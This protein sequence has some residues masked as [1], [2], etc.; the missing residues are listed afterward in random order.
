[1]TEPQPAP[2]S[3]GYIG[4]YCIVGILARGGMGEV[5][6]A[7]DDRLNRSVAIKRIRQDLDNPTLRQR[8]LQEA[9][10]VGGLHHPAIVLVYDLLEHEGD[11]CIVMEHVEGPTVAEA[12]KTG[13]LEPGPAVRLAETVASGLAAAHEAGFIHRDLKAENVKVTPSGD[14]KILDFGL[15]KPLGTAPDDPSLTAAGH[16]V[17]TC[18]SMSPEQASG[19]EVDERSDLF[20]LGVL[21]YEMLAGISPFQSSSA[22][23][24]LHKVIYERP[25]CLDTLR[26]GLPPRLVALLYRLLAKEPADRPQ[27][28]VEVV[29]E[30]QEIAASLSLSGDLDPEQTVSALPTDTIRRWGGDPTPPRPTLQAVPAPP[31]ERPPRRGRRRRLE[32]AILLSLPLLLGVAIL[33]HWLIRPRPL[34]IVVPSPEISGDPQLQL[35]ASSVQNACEDHLF[36]LGIPVIDHR[37]LN[38]LPDSS[39]I[40]QVALEAAADEVLVIDARRSDNSS[41]RVELRCIRGKDGQVLWLEDLQAP[42]ERQDFLSLK[43]DALLRKHLSGRPPGPRVPAHVEAG[44]LAAFYLI[45]RQ[46]EQG[47]ISPESALPQLQA[48]IA[49]SR[50][51]LDAQLLAADLATD[52]F[53]SR[54]EKTDYDRALN[55]IEQAEKLA[56]E[57]PRPLES[58]FRLQ[59]ANVRFDEA[60]KTLSNLEDLRPGDP[61]N[62]TLRADLE[63]AQGQYGK[64]LA[65]QQGAVEALPSWQNILKLAQLEGQN[66][67]IAEARSHLNNILED[68]P[69]NLWAQQR[70]GELEIEFGDP[71]RAEAI[72]Q[73]LISRSSDPASTF[74]YLANLG[75]ARVLLSRYSD[76][77]AALNEAL[78]IDPDNVSATLN[79]ADAK[80]GLGQTNDAQ[81][82]YSKI[83]QQLERNAPSGHTAYEHIEAQCLAHLGKTH[84]AREI[85]QRA[86]G[87]NADN[88]DILQ[89]A[90]LVYA[91][92]G[93][94]DAALETIQIALGKQLASR[95]FKTP[96]YSPLFGDPKFQQLVD[97]GKKQDR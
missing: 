16:V 60:A 28:A 68:S 51:F 55:L 19:A 74:S 25:P 82:L 46:F 95:W 44:D 66:G 8:L 42:L 75:V 92:A 2:G 24:T 65:D 48:I 59:M 81:A 27:S 33:L 97:P 38:G 50:H 30:L 14:A 21:L 91:L 62:L 63:K 83:L 18:R 45:Q 80:L 11:D 22:P 32:I 71:E 78:K 6:L 12:L 23:A 69:G 9:R 85:I 64:A 15:A 29:R 20:S 41:A 10:A 5:Y 67:R 73:K 40:S 76:A 58:L 34:R 86:L 93:D 1:M 39:Q 89:S 52:L 37:Q 17:G 4:P 70:L 77:V 49:R 90:V 84:E 7:R 3:G 88:M 61:E 35:L 94:R 43:V 26:P 96:S 47:K 31:P 87:R 56:S 79:L 72:Y 54:H 13:P 36:S 53:Q 57:D